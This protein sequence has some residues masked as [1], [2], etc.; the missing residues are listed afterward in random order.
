[1]D[2]F[3]AALKGF[4]KSKTGLTC[5]GLALSMLA[6]PVRAWVAAHPGEFGTAVSAAFAALRSVTNTSLVEKGSP[7][8]SPDA[9][10]G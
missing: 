1:M 7:P 9:K 5:L 4:L 10:G 6:E 8:E 3:L 2:K